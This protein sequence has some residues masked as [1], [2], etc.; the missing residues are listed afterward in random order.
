MEI[1]K[2]ETNKSTQIVTAKIS[3]LNRKF[4]IMENQICAIGKELAKLA[5]EI[6]TL[7]KVLKR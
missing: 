6:D 7:K 3:T 2:N 1:D 4:S 5:K